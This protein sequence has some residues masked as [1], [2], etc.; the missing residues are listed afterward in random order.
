MLVLQVILVTAVSVAYL[1]TLFRGVR[2]AFSFFGPEGG[3][4]TQL[5]SFF[6]ALVVPFVGGYFWNY[7]GIFNIHLV[8]IPVIISAFALGFWKTRRRA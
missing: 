7:L 5:S 2:H 8:T 4:R 1:Y 6:F 3:Q